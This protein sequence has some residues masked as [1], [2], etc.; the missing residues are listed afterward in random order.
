[1]KRVGIG[2]ALLL[3][4]ACSSGKSTSQPSTTTT[5]A[6][7]TPVFAKGPCVDEV[8]VDAR[9]ECGTLTVPEDRSK[10]TGRQVVMPV[11]IVH[12]ADPNPAPDP[13]VYFS[14]GPGQAGLFTADGFLNKG[15]AGNR[16]VILFDQRGTG[17]A[18]PGLDCSE[19]NEATAT[20][21]G[22]ADAFGTE[23]TV[24]KD[25]LAACRDRLRAAG[26]DLSQYN[27]TTVADDVADL[28]LAMGIT[29][30][31]LFGVSYGTTVALAVMRAHPEG[32]RSVTLDSV[33]PMDVG[34]GAPE[35][36]S[37]FERV[38]RVFFDGCASD[39]R[40]QAAYPN[41]E[42]DA[43]SVFAAFDASPYQ[44]TIDN[45]RLHR[46]TPIV[47]TGADIAAGLFNA[48]YDTGL[49]PQ[50]PSLI[51]QLKAGTG[52]PIIDLLTV[53]G[54]DLIDSFAAAQ[55]AAVNCHDR[56]AFINNGDTERVLTDHPEDAT[57]M[58]YN[59]IDCSDFG[60]PA[61]PKGFNDPVRSDIPTLVL[62]DEYD[63]VTPPEQSK[64]AADSLSRSTFV[65]FPGL[66]HGAVFAAPECPEILFRAFL[67]D[68]TAPLD[69][70]CVAAMGP[71][72]WAVSG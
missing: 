43:A 50:L 65:K 66:G 1:V 44:S 61:A 2:I 28:R 48:F 36:S 15:Q 30:W 59:A 39:P 14:G 5:L 55:A 8:P 34:T 11:A 53:R 60:V 6:N 19:V 45:P 16:D 37:S 10:P 72:A 38:K 54:I 41:L 57:L 3:F 62:G 23:A 20:V 47:I 71:P 69:T 32:V 9:I 4:A 52:G 35:V 18:Q 42:A 12:T 26:V 7:Y 64:H 22:A 25:A 27:T 49:I 40:C 70:S 31:N 13:V 29:E 63:P 56:A 68:P 46:Q 24:A 67:A 17:E 58:L 21:F 51:E 33:V